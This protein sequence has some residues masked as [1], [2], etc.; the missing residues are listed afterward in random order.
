MLVDR[1]SLL[2]SQL[3]P[4]R[5]RFPLR[6]DLRYLIWLPWEKLWTESANQPLFKDKELSTEICISTCMYARNPKYQFHSECSL[7]HSHVG[8]FSGVPIN[9]LFATSTDFLTHFPLDKLA[10]ISQTIFSDAFPLMKSFV[11][12]LQFHLI[13]FPGSNWQ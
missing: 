6:D 12:R 7:V 13:I 8:Y 11:F 4:P 10:S 9:R 2:Q 1:V 5:W 3:W